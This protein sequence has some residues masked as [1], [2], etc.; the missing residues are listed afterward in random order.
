MRSIFI[1]VVFSLYPTISR[2]FPLNNPIWFNSYIQNVSACVSVIHSLYDHI[3]KH[4]HENPISNIFP[5]YPL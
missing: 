3:P 1:S 2:H 5:L 4:V